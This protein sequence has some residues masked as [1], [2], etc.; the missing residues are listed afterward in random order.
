MLALWDDADLEDEAEA[1]IAAHP[2]NPLT[3]GLRLRIGSMA[4]LAVIIAAGPQEPH[5]AEAVEAFM[6]LESACCWTL[7]EALTR[8]GAL[9]AQYPGSEVEVLAAAGMAAACLRRNR[10][11]QALEIVEEAM[12]KLAAERPFL[13]RLEAQRANARNQIAA[14]RDGTRMAAWSCATGLLTHTDFGSALS[15]DSARLYAVTGPWEQGRHA[16]AVD[17]KTGRLVWTSAVGDVATLEAGGDR[18]FYATAHG[19][20]GCLEA[21]TGAPLWHRNLGPARVGYSFLHYRPSELVVLWDQSVL[22]GLHAETG[23]FGWRRDLPLCGS[24]YKSHRPPIVSVRDDLIVC[25]GSGPSMCGWPCDGRER[26][27]SVP[28]ER[29]LPELPAYCEDEPLPLARCGDTVALA[30]ETVRGPVLLGLDAH[31]GRVRWQ[32]A[33]PG[34][35]DLFMDASEAAGAPLVRLERGLAECSPHDGSVRWSLPLPQGGGY[36]GLA[37][38]PSFV[39]VAADRSILIVHRESGHVSHV[40]ETIR[41]PWYLVAEEDEGALYLYVFHEQGIDAYDVDAGGP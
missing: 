29:L 27:W 16:R 23:E 7:D 5:F 37:A 24:G 13:E 14:K 8:Y 34:G 41:S 25:W 10:P 15:R 3:S 6:A 19:S 22:F 18:V 33:L 36:G 28:L 2:D 11:E 1:A 35:M 39:A 9:A 17:R 12:G 30:G 4:H 40:V 38:T 31:S 26:L 20:V 21:A 32:T